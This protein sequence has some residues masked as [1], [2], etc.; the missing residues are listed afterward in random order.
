MFFTRFLSQLTDHFSVFAQLPRL[1]PRS[2]PRA[3]MSVLFVGF[4]SGSSMMTG[5][6]HAVS[7]IM[8]NKRDDMQ[9]GR[10]IMA[11]K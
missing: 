1:L 3:A 11:A 2:L 10:F 9:N 7:Q 4:F 8:Q 5:P 6:V